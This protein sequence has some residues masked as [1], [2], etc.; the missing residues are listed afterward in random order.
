MAMCRNN[1]PIIFQNLRDFIQQALSVNF[2]KGISK[3]KKPDFLLAM[4][5]CFVFFQTI[6][7]ASVELQLLFTFR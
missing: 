4:S 3:I 1:F 6:I 2:T 5:A 7:R